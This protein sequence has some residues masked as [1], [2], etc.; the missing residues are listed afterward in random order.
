MEINDSD[1]L[2]PFP[3]LNVNPS[4]NSCAVLLPFSQRIWD[5][6]KNISSTV[7]A[8]NPVLSLIQYFQG[9]NENSG[10]VAYNSSNLKK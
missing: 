10:V 2:T 5:L 8:Q 3:T 6:G 7:V 1:L 4:C 9:K